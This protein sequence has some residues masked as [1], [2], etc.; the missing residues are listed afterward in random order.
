[1]STKQ[2]KK[3]WYWLNGSFV[4]VGVHREEG[5]QSI[6]KGF[7]QAQNAALQEFGGTQKVKKL[8]RFKIGDV[9]HTIKAGTILTTPARIF[10][11]IFL[12]NKKAQRLLNLKFKYE[13]DALFKNMRGTGKKNFWNKMGKW[14]TDFIKFRL[15]NGEITPELSSFTLEAR[16]EQGIK[17]DKPLYAK[18]KLHKDIKFKRSE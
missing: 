9:W 3:M 12:T 18:G 8:R 13:I 11:R 5:R 16:K 14:A 7:N 2:A 1:M 6:S 10:L 17:G 15:K 4:T